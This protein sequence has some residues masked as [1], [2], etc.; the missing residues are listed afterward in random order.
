MATSVRYRGIRHGSSTVDDVEVFVCYGERET[1]L[2]HIVRHSP[3]GMNWGYNGSG[4]ADLALSI[5]THLLGR[6]PSPVVYQAFKNQTIAWINTNEWSLDGLVIAGWLSAHNVT[7]GPDPHRL[8][9]DLDEEPATIALRVGWKC[10]YADEPEQNDS[11]VY[12]SWAEFVAEYPQ[13][14][15]VLPQEPGATLVVTAE[16]WR[17][18]FNVEESRIS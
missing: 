7:P 11:G 12:R 18:S 16:L 4:P 9:D 5:L 14:A 3:D 13:V 1:P 15:A 8:Y 6:E 10:E 17:Q 2:P